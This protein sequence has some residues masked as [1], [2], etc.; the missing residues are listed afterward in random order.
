MTAGTGDTYP[1]GY[2][3]LA[4]FI[5]SDPEISIFRR[6]GYLHLR[7][8]L[9]LQDELTL[10]EQQLHH[11]DV[12]ERAEINN[13]SWRH[14]TNEERRKLMSQ[15]RTLLLEYGTVDLQELFT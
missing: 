14:D 13:M 12:T 11:I 2:P 1:R 7:Q 5:T 3:E 15:I 10:L 8:L 9:Y 6:F 4:A